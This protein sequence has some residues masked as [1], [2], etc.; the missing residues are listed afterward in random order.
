ME[1]E[2]AQGTDRCTYLA[3]PSVGA[4]EPAV[5]TRRSLIKMTRTIVVCNKRIEGFRGFVTQGSSE[6][7][8]RCRWVKSVRG[9][10]AISMTHG[11]DQP[12]GP[13]KGRGFRAGSRRGQFWSSR[14]RSNQAQGFS[15][16]SKRAY[17][18]AKARSYSDRGARCR[19][20]VPA[21]RF[22]PPFSSRYRANARLSARSG[23]VRNVRAR[24]TRRARRRAPPLR[25]ARRRHL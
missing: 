6:S 21:G 23:A 18:F 13:R 14:S 12:S 20:G 4:S 10:R 2:G 19:A 5:R 9:S 15:Q 24:R 11:I 17:L 7:A 22:N 8:N 16:Q 1:R 3:F 25:G